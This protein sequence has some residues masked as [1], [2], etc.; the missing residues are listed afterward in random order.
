M[1]ERYGRV[2]VLS[3]YRTVTYNIAVGGVRNSFHVYT[4][5]KAYPA[6]DFRCERGSPELWGRAARQMLGSSGGVGV[7]PG[8]GFTHAD[9]RPVRSDWRG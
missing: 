6:V 9:T 4:E 5:R 8:Q 7:Y 3:G 2:T 1:R